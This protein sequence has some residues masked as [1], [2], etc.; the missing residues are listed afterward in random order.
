MAFLALNPNTTVT[1]PSGTWVSIGIKGFI[2]T[3]NN[4]EDGHG[5][6]G[7]AGSNYTVPIPYILRALKFH[8]HCQKYSRGN[9]RETD[10]WVGWPFCVH[11][12]G[13]RPWEICGD[14]RQILGTEVAVYYPGTLDGTSNGA[15][16]KRDLEARKVGKDWKAWNNFHLW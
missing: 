8:S 6:N 7:T 16:W 5:E 15:D 14:K 9:G 12:E 1:V 4:G 13:G 11:D 10:G 3:L 2:V